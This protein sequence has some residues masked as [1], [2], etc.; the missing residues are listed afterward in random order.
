MDKYLK[1]A[2]KASVS[3]TLGKAGISGMTGGVNVAAAPQENSKVRVPKI[4]G[5]HIY[6][7]AGDRVRTHVHYAWKGTV[8]DEGVSILTQV[9]KSED[10]KQVHLVYQDGGFPLAYC[11]DHPDWWREFEHV[12]DSTPCTDFT[13]V[14]RQAKINP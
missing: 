11:K 5:G 4:G 7:K 6:I 9:V 13:K 2:L 10:G 8:W 3:D 14:K 1:S 12:P